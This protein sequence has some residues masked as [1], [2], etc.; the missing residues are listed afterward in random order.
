M[1]VGSNALPFSG[2]FIGGAVLVVCPN[3]PV[4]R[5]RCL[6]QSNKKA[7]KRTRTRIQEVRFSLPFASI[8]IS[9]EADCFMAVLGVDLFHYSIYVVLDREFR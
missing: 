8:A 1:P 3:V 4:R 9:N 2:I 5:C 7:A 6:G